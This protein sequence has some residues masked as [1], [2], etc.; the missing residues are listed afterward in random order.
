MTPLTHLMTSGVVPYSLL[1]RK[2]VLTSV[3]AG[4]CLTVLHAL[5]LGRSVRSL[6]CRVLRFWRSDLTGAL[7]SRAVT[8]LLLLQ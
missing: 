4:L 3:C 2:L 6:V 8:L 1:T 7:V 5:G